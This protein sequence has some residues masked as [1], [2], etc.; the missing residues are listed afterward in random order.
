MLPVTLLLG[1]LFLLAAD[2]LCRCL[3]AVE[4][5]IGILTSFLGAPFFLALM[6]RKEASL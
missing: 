4:I 1:A 5:P 3:L 2:D 6:L